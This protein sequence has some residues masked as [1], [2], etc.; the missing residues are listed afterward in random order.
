MRKIE[1]NYSQKFY[2]V[3]YKTVNDKL[4]EMDNSLVVVM[5]TE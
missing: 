4:L 1:K 2:T 5:E 3:W